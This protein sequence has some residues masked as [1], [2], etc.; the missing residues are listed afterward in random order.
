M[1]AGGTA[2]H[3]AP[4]LAVADELRARGAHVEFAVSTRPADADTVAAHGYVSHTFPIGG[5]PRTPGVAQFRAIWRALAAVPRCMGIVRR[6]QPDVLLAGGGYVSAPAAI[7]SR[8]LRVPV[9]VTEADAHLGLANRI[10]ARVAEVLC[11]AYPLPQFRDRQLVTGRPVSP[12]FVD[13]EGAGARERLSIPA[14]HAVLAV[15]GGSGGALHLNRVVHEA[16]GDDPDPHVGGT[17]LHVVHVTGRRDHHE[18]E[19]R[20]SSPRYRIVEYCDDMPSLLGAADLVVSRAGGSV[21]ELAAAGR[22]AVLVPSPFVTADH[23]M[24]NALHFERG[25]GA[26]LVSHTEFTSE[27][28]LGLVEDLLSDAGSARRLEMATAMRRLARPDAA[29]AIADQLEQVARRRGTD[30]RG[31]QTT[32]EMRT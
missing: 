12:S 25:G 16:Y 32:A 9:V 18:F 11:S 15:V 30:A 29:T 13:V 31:T 3:L 26:V 21:F 1:A 23:Q 24:R 10:S 7:A 8:M 2:G 20:S 27:R 17:P 28:L 14:G 5:L 22:A 19:G 4:A 6:V